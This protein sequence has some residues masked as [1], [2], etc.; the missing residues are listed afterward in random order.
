MQ[1]FKVNG[2]ARNGNCN[3][4]MTHKMPVCYQICD[5]WCWATGVTMTGDYYKG[6]NY[7]QGFECSVASHEFGG[8]C[9][10]YTTLAK[11]STMPQH[12]LATAEEHPPICEMHPH[13]S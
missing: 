11:A 2:S 1:D 6:Q 9:C 13:T 5:E 7:C 10:P 4:D 8:K 3:N 12:L